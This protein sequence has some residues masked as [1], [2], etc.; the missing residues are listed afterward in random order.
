MTHQGP[1]VVAATVIA[2]EDRSGVHP[3]TLFK[4]KMTFSYNRLPSPLIQLLRMDVAWICI[5]KV[6]K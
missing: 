4:Y 3:T 1:D 5:L 2:I 6:K